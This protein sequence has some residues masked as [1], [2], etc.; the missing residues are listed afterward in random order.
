MRLQAVAERPDGSIARSTAM[1][2][3]E[4]ADRGGVEA[5]CHAAESRRSRHVKGRMARAAEQQ[6][7][8][9]VWR[10]AR[11]PQ[12]GPGT[13]V[14]NLSAPAL[15]VAGKTPDDTKRRGEAQLQRVLRWAE[16]KPRFGRACA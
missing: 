12:A 7:R 1:E 16:R 15:D 10:A 13:L 6:R 9:E 2:Q 11:D 4:V 5:I 8:L 14:G 3:G